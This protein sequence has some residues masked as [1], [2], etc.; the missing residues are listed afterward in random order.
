[1]ARMPWLKHNA[2]AEAVGAG[3]GDK[4]LGGINVEKPIRLTTEEVR[5]IL[6]G[7]EV[8]NDERD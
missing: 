4:R 8:S 3:A 6:E 7:K 1:V 5:E 2:W